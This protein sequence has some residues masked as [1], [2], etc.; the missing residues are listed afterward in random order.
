M[1]SFWNGLDIFQKKKILI[2]C[3]DFFNFFN[4]IEKNSGRKKKLHRILNS[5]QSSLHRKKNPVQFYFWIF[6]GTR[7]SLIWCGAE[8]NCTEFKFR[9]RAFCTGKNRPV[10]LNLLIFDFLFLFY[11]FH[12]F[13]FYIKKKSNCS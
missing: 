6:C 2:I 12:L 7:S 11:Y 8:Q 3:F 4:D 9:C 10:S 5:V 13:Y 1:I